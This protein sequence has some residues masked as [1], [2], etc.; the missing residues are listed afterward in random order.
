[1]NDS[2]AVPPKL[3]AVAPEKFDPVSSTLLLPP[4]GPAEG[5]TALIDEVEPEVTVKWSEEDV[6]EVPA[7]VVTVMSTVAAA[8]G[9]A[10]AVICVALLTTTVL[11]GTL[12]KFT[13]LVLL[14]F[15][16][17]MVTTVPPPP[18]PDDGDTAETVGA[19]AVLKV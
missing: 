6:A 18:G 13:W 12:P 4:S 1:V 10:T 8:W 15:V 16:P 3:T 14:K 2:A 7:A 17:V 19:D 5:P 11:A 9:G